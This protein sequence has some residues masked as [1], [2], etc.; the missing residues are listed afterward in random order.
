MS[1]KS[2]NIWPYTGY[3][4]R[5]T[6]GRNRAGVAEGNPGAIANKTAGASS[7]TMIY[8]R[9]F[10]YQ[11]RYLKSKLSMFILLQ[12]LTRGVNNKLTSDILIEHIRH[13]NDRGNLPK[14][15]STHIVLNRRGS[16]STARHRNPYDTQPGADSFADS[17]TTP[18]AS[19]D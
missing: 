15:A 19:N 9:G 4:E 5:R 13:L 8:H 11:M 16:S 14:G 18:V 10:P 7:M 2:W 3:C 6:R 17:P 12:C 1:E